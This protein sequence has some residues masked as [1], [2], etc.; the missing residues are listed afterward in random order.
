MNGRRRNQ[1]K[2]RKEGS[3]DEKKCIVTMV[4]LWLDCWH[5]GGKVKDARA[6]GTRKG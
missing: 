3:E 2:G 4:S 6:K 1:T 5:F